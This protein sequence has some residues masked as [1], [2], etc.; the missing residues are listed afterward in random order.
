L[1]LTNPEYDGDST[2]DRGLDGDRRAIH[3]RVQGETYHPTHDVVESS[4]LTKLI[5]ESI[6]AAPL[7]SCDESIRTD[8]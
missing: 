5:F 7:V 2:G 3:D 1:W 8:F 6:A 4:G